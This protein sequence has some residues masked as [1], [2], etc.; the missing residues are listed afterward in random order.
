L[1][2]RNAMNVGPL[3][4]AMTIATSAATRTLPISS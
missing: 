4:I 1:L 3:R 2:R